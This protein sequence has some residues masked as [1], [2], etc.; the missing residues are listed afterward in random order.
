[1]PLGSG[2]AR[3]RLPGPAGLGNH[4][5]DEAHRA[6]RQP[7]T[8]TCPPPTDAEAP[9]P[10]LPTAEIDGLIVAS[11]T[12]VGYL[13]GFTGEDSV[14]LLTQERAIVVSDGRFSVQLAQECPDLEADDPR[15]SASRC[16]R[17]S[18]SWRS[19]SASAAS[20]FES[21]ATTVAEF[22]T[23]REAAGGV[24]L[25]PKQGLVERLRMIKDDGRDR[26][27]P[28]GRRPSPSGPSSTSAP[29]SDPA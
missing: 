1:M 29:G 14:L 3:R 20:A 15:R 13:T 19:R 4:G 25:V 8:S 26:R 6:A 10:V 22:D 12:N 7:E 24:E 9:P 11:P 16:P 5:A 28:R 17:R 18:A 2:T 21:Q 27:D 23:L